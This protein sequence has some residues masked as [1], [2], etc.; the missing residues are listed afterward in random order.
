M[1][2]MGIAV[3]RSSGGNLKLKA[4]IVRLVM[5]PIS[6]IP[7]FAG[8]VPVLFDRRR[9]ALPDMLSGAVVRYRDGKAAARRESP[10]AT[11]V[12]TR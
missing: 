1:R 5:I 7:L 12:S 11:A 2:W 8:Y 9:R 4:A 3:E 6:A 10:D